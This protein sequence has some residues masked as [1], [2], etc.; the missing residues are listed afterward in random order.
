MYDHTLHGER[1]QDTKDT[2]DCSKSNGKQMITMPENN[3][4]FKNW[5][6][7]IKS[8]FMI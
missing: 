4:R 1:K 5:E 6:R 2:N 3:V 7:K 8:S